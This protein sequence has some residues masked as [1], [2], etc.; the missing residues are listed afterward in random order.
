MDDRASFHSALTAAARKMV[1]VV[2]AGIAAR[3]REA[4]VVGDEECRRNQSGDVGQ[5]SGDGGVVRDHTDKMGATKGDALEEPMRG[6]GGAVWGIV[7]VFPGAGYPQLNSSSGDGIDSQTNLRLS[8]YQVRIRELL[9]ALAYEW[10]AHK[11][12]N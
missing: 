5:C 10:A 8:A 3:K 2:V 9:N 12:D 6:G 1:G 4:E 11:Q 7:G